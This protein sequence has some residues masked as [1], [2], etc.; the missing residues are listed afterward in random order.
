MIQ[1]FKNVP[2]FCFTRTW[3]SPKCLWTPGVVQPM[4][5]C[6]T[7][8]QCSLTSFPHS[9]PIHTVWY[10]ARLKGTLMITFEHS[11]F[12]YLLHKF[13]IPQIQ[14]F[15]LN[16]TTT[17]GVLFICWGWVSDF[18]LKWNK[19]KQNKTNKNLEQ[20]FSSLSASLRDQNSALLVV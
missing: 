17:L 2:P 14:S 19:A 5:T 11:P 18:R 3:V 8:N 7:T 6:S 1:V 20:S 15:Q 13:W 12:C 9:K 4:D 10:L 16:K